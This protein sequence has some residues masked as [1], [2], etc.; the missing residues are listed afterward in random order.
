MWATICSALWTVTSSIT[1]RTA[2]L[3][4]RTVV[5]RIVPELMKAF[6]NPIDFRTL[7]RTDLLLIALVVALFDGAC[8][9]QFTQ[10]RVPFRF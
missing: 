9:F 6:W 2:R 7:F 4:W 3:R 5:A 1:N 10:F 8:L